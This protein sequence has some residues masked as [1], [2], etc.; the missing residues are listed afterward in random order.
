MPHKY[1]GTLLGMG[2]KNT[3]SDSK[4]FMIWW[5]RQTREQ[6]LIIT[7]KIVKL[8]VAD[9]ILIQ[10]MGRRGTEVSHGL[11]TQQLVRV[12]RNFFK[13]WNG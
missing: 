7:V 11:P 10:G 4:E 1:S 12:S 8:I 9:L 5:R 13:S 3:I 6:L 2:E